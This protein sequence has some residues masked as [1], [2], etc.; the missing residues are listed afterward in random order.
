MRTENISWGL[1][2][3]WHRTRSPYARSRASEVFTHYLARKL[4]PRG[5]TVNAI[6]PGANATD[7]SG[8]WCTMVGWSGGG[9]TAVGRVEEPD[10]IGPMI[11][12]LLTGGNRSAAAQRIE[13]SAA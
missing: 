13:V 1:T 10:D 9:L 2:G 8:G 7:F 6:A 11:A 3:C 4:G 5:I 12:S